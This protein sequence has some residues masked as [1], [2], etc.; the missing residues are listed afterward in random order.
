MAL[1]WPAFGGADR[2]AS[3]SEDELRAL[4]VTI[5]QFKKKQQQNVRQSVLSQ[6]ICVEVFSSNQSMTAPATVA[7]SFNSEALE[8]TINETAIHYSRPATIFAAVAASIFTFVG[9]TGKFL[10]IITIH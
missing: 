7:A 10:M 6:K 2:R 1:T 8:A 4:R 5:R 9:I 3:D